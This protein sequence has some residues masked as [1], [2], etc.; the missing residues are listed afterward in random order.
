[1][2]LVMDIDKII[3]IISNTN[4]VRI[5]GYIVIFFQLLILLRLVIRAIFIKLKDK[6]VREKYWEDTPDELPP[7]AVGVLMYGNE[8]FEDC[9]AAEIANFIEKGLIRG[10][11]EQGSLKLQIIRG[12][13]E[14]DNLWDYQYTI[15]RKFIEDK[16]NREGIVSVESF[17]ENNSV[18]A[19]SIPSINFSVRRELVKRDYLKERVIEPCRDKIISGSII[20]FLVWVVLSIYM[21]TV[22]IDIMIIPIIIL[23]II[24]YKIAITNHREDLTDKGVQEYKKWLSF[25]KFLDNYGKFA[26]RGTIDIVIWRKFLVY[27]CA[28]DLSDK[29]TDEVD[30]LMTKEIVK[31]LKQIFLNIG[32]NVLKG[33]GKNMLK[34]SFN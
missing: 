11:K 8:K 9:L 34:N 7:F 3:S 32:K 10:I 29:L 21:T 18:A 1:M 26:D 14:N 5:V 2:I 28:F 20:T 24:M 16:A 6:I 27:A 12:P 22:L 4:K 13:F 31:A 15:F 30:D 23:L 25:R 33:I 19:L 17:K